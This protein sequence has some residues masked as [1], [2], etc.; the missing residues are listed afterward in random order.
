MDCADEYQGDQKKALQS[1]ETYHLEDVPF[2]DP[3][4]FPRSIAGKPI[5]PTVSFLGQAP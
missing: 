4:L 3:S 5:V 2:W 1:P